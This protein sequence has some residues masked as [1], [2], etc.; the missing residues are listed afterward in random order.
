M[1]QKKN[2]DVLELIRGSAGKLY[3]NLTSVLVMMKG[4]PL[5]YNRDMQLDKEPLFSSFKIVRN[6]LVILSK[7]ISQ[8]KVNKEKIDKQLEDESLYATDLAHYLV[9][10][11]VA[12][13]Q[14]HSIIGNLVS[15][16]LS[17]KLKIKDMSDGQLGKFSKYLSRAIIEKLLDPV[18]SV[19]SKKS[20]RI[21]E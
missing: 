1:P 18:Y 11:G 10:Q 15:F 5:S 13:Q 21:R 12:F 7:L 17:K 8:I 3:G 16:S 20:A 2:P 6:E 19:K 14:A 4:L 9:E